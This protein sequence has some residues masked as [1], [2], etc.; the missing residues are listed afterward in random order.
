[1]IKEDDSQRFELIKGKHF[2]AKGLCDWLNSN[3]AEKIPQEKKHAFNIN[4]IHQYLL[5]NRGL[6]EY[7][8]GKNKLTER[9]IV[10][11]IRIIELKWLN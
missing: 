9:S 1:M 4:D 6:P 11:G 10:G 3:H 5:P 2:S 7:I 8:G